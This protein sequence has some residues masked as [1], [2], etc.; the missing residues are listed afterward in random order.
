MEI[1][2]VLDAS[3]FINGFKINSDNNFTVPEIT[4]EIKE[5]I[6]DEEKINATINK[7]QILIPASVP[8]KT[9][10]VIKK[11]KVKINVKFPEKYEQIF[12]VRQRLGIKANEIISNCATEEEAQKK[13]SQICNL[14]DAN[15]EYLSEDAK[16][17]ALKNINCYLENLEE[18]AGIVDM[19]PES[20]KVSFYN[21]MA[22]KELSIEA[23][24]TWNRTIQDRGLPFSN[25]NDLKRLNVNDDA[26]KA[27][28]T[29]KTRSWINNFE[30]MDPE[31]KTFRIQMP[32]TSSL[33]TNF[34]NIKTLFEILS[35]EK[36]DLP[37]KTKENIEKEDIVSELENDYLKNGKTTYPKLVKYL[38]VKGHEIRNAES[39]R[40]YQF[41]KNFE[42]L[43]DVINNP[44]FF[45]P[46]FFSPHSKLR[47]IE[48]Y[49]LN[50][51]Y[52]ERIP[53]YKVVPNKTKEFIKNVKSA[54]MQGV[55]ARPYQAGDVTGVQLL[56]PTENGEIT[57]ITLDNESKIHTII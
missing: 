45:D 26:I 52:D 8:V 6:N 11:E 27:I 14:L 30:I 32:T 36:V 22:N 44:K 38:Y 33:K 18:I 19:L 2:Y 43:I 31:T 47:F 48:R 10:P 54:L 16:T 50:E 53:L 42:A 41:D 17:N 25:Y 24:K 39:L 3:A 12:K 9:K 20:E 51:D 35:G 5:N 28:T 57:K 49:V 56:I 34:G 46:N 4:T 37:A 21:K 29:M 40:K 55:E 23:L 13:V 15:I 1:C 7:Y